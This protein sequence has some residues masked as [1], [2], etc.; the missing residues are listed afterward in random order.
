MVKNKGSL[1]E[2]YGNDLNESENGS[3]HLVHWFRRGLRLHDNPALLEGISLRNTTL[4]NIFGF[5]HPV[6]I[7]TYFFAH[8]S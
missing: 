7:K 2:S 5:A 6:Q 4:R 8:V 1:I 3:K